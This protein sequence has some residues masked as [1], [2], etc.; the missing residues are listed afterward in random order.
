MSKTAVLLISFPGCGK[1][2]AMEAYAKSIG[3]KF[4]CHVA[5]QEDPVDITGCVMPDENGLSCS[6]RLPAW[7]IRACEEPYVILF[8]EVSACDS[9]QFSGILRATDDSRELCGMKLHNDTEIFAA[10]NPP[11]M[12]AGSARELSPPV[13]NRFRIRYLDAEPAIN[14]MCGELGL[15][16]TKGSNHPVVRI[17]GEYLKNN[18]EAAMATVDQIQKA[19]SE[20]RPFPSP[21][22]WTRA[23]TEIGLAPGN[24]IPVEWAEFVG[25]EPVSMFRAFLQKLDLPNVVDILAGRCLDVPTR[26]DAVMVTAGTISAMLC[27]GQEPSAATIK[28]ASSWFSKAAKEGFVASVYPAVGQLIRHA[29]ETLGGDKGLER[30]SVMDVTPFLPA[31]KSAGEIK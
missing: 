22:G 30:W 26:G 19:A 27:G 25:I 31:L 15:F 21:R 18:R 28:H 8:D 24:L 1:S 4:S 20:Q 14:W 2:T 13:L 10:M 16:G 9:S 17:V 7:W 3:K 12:A 5:A 29:N 11:D 23:A 6:R